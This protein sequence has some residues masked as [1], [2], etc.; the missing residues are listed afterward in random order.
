[1]QRKRKAMTDKKPNPDDMVW[2]DYGTAS[3]RQVLENIKT[4]DPAVFAGKFVVLSSGASNNPAEIDLLA[5]QLEVL[6]AAGALSIGVLGVGSVPDSQQLDA[7]LREIIHAI[8][9]TDP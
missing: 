6:H 8:G 9:L 3:P 5:R 4:T 1:M 7:R 2:L